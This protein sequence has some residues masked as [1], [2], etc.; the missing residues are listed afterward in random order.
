MPAVRRWKVGLAVL[1]LAFAG[2]ADT[3]G[4]SDAV[5]RPKAKP[6]DETA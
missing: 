6:A 5:K 4:P 2:C 3:V 1:G